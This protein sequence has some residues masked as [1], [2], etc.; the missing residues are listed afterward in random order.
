MNP[1]APLFDLNGRVAVVT[2]GNG[3]IGRAIAL[4]LARAG[5]SVA[6]LARN[7]EKN[8]L[9]LAEPQAIGR[10]AIAIRLDVTSRPALAPTIASVE[11]QLGGLDILVNNAGIAPPGKG[12]LDEAADN[13]DNTIETHLNAC[14]LLSQVAARSMAGRKSGKII[15]LASMYS[16]FG[17]G[18]LPAYSA[19]KGAVVQ[20]TKSMPSQHPGQCNRSRVDRNGHDSPGPK[21]AHE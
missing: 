19:A 3:G 8:G 16:Y 7:E 4:G 17:S 20:L 5:A 18:F 13:W 6:V 15:N 11:Q 21:L 12:A 1:E 14:F 9:V 10:P 2:G